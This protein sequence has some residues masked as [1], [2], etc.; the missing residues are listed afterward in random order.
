[1]KKVFFNKA[2]YL[3]ST[4]NSQVTGNEVSSRTRRLPPESPKII[5]LIAILQWEN[6]SNYSS[7]VV[8]VYPTTRLSH[9]VRVFRNRY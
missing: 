3:R 9:S 8:S 5:L 4:S 7:T 1:M 2:I 6:L